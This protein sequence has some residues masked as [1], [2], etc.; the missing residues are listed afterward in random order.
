MKDVFKSMLGNT[1]T[2]DGS[3]L[4]VLVVLAALLVHLDVDE[5]LGQVV[6]DR[7]VE[8]G[9]VDTLDRVDVLTLRRR[10]VR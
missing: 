1:R 4:V 5:A 8:S 10:C 9:R 3:S 6:R 2:P 7:L